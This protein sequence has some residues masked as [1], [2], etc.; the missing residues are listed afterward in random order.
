M[1]ELVETSIAL[2]RS[3]WRP[4]LLLHLAYTGLGIIVFAPLLGMLGSVLLKLSGK[5]AA[6]WA[7]HGR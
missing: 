1:R 3:R 4:I 6:P 5:P 7:D 2:L